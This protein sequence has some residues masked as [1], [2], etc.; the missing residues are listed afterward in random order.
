MQKNVYPR[1]AARES[2]M[3]S[4]GKIGMV[5]APRCG[6]ETHVCRRA[7]AQGEQWKLRVIFVW[8]AARRPPCELDVRGRQ[9]F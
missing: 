1:N 7:Y 4:A 8:K 2:Q 3:P 9:F 6:L 5:S